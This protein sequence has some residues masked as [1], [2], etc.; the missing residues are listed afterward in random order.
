MTF[1]VTS[2][3]RGVQ[4]WHHGVSDIERGPHY[5]LGLFAENSR[6]L[7]G[8][9]AVVVVSHERIERSQLHPNWF[10]RTLSIWK[11]TQIENELDWHDLRT[12]SSSVVSAE[13]PQMSEPTI[14]TPNM[15]NSSMTGIE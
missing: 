13:K 6:V 2:V 10:D 12:Q 8:A 11:P 3:E 9:A 1:D 7:V 4:I 15:L 5:V 14:V